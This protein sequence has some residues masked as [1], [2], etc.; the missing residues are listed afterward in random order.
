MYYNSMS[1]LHLQHH[2]STSETINNNI[3]SIHNPIMHKFKKYDDLYNDKWISY[4]CFN[5][6]V[7]HYYAKLLEYKLKQ[8]YQYI[9][10]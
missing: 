10:N 3:Y 5:W 2:F 6:N 1:S 9:I 7:H 8:N 4:S